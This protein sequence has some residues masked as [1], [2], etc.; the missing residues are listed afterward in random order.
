MKI[1]P[2]LIPAQ[3][4]INLSYFTCNPITNNTKTTYANLIYNFYEVQRKIETKC[5]LCG[6]IRFIFYKTDI[7]LIVVRGCKT[8]FIKW[9]HC[10]RVC[11]ISF[12]ITCLLFF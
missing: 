4:S 8:L 3:L 7:I 10:R 11:Q 2:N 5:D 6:W 12:D 9:H 1:Y